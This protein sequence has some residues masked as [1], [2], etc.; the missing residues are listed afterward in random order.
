MNNWNDGCPT[1]Y[2]VKREYRRSDS[3]YNH[4]KPFKVFRI[5]TCRKWID[6][7]IRECIELE[8]GRYQH[9]MIDK[10]FAMN[11]HVAR[12]IQR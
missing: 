11:V 2:W 9:P 5:E 6:M 12:A 8:D 10:S 3:D 7:F 4:N 1:F